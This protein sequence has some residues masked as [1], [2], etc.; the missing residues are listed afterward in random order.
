MKK[1]FYILFA[2]SLFSC[3]SNDDR[4]ENTTDQDLQ[5][6]KAYLFYTEFFTIGNTPL[7]N[8]YY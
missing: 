6:D 4:S 5:P 1:I 2:L 8:A 3:S 7:S